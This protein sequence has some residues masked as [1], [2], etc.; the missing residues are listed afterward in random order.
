MPLVRVARGGCIADHSWGGREAES[1]RN[2]WMSQDMSG[3]VRVG[4]KQLIMRER[5]AKAR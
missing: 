2:A 3:E 4:K 1:D 5:D